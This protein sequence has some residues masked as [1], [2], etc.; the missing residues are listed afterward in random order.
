M[1]PDRLAKVVREEIKKEFGKLRYG[2]QVALQR[3][4][5]LFG[6]S[7]TV[8]LIAT[9]SGLSRLIAEVDWLNRNPV[10]L[11]LFGL[12]MLILTGTLYKKI[13]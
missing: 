4:P 10:I 13:Q 7:A 5:L 9:F 1:H 3:F 2:R 11:L 8:G 6:L 12:F